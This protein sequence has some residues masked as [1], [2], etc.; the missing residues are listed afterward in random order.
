MYGLLCFDVVLRFFLKQNSC[1]I[2]VFGSVFV[3]LLGFE[4]CVHFLVVSCIGMCR[5]LFLGELF[6][7]LFCLLLW[8]GGCSLC[9]VMG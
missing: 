5:V 6:V 9:H 2:L 8:L 4:S 1:C 3:V 7:C